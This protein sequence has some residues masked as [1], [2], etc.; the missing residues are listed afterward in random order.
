MLASFSFLIRGNNIS[1]VVRRCLKLLTRRDMKFPDNLAMSEQVTLD[2]RDANLSTQLSDNSLTAKPLVSGCISK[3][4]SGVKGNSSASAGKPY[5]IVTI[6]KELAGDAAEGQPEVLIGV[7]TRETTAAQLGSG[8]SW[9]YASSGRKWT[10]SKAEP[11][12]PMFA[13][14]DE[15]GCFLDLNSDTCTVSF[16]FNGTWLGSAYELPKPDHAQ[17]RLYPHIML[18]RLEATVNFTDAALSDLYT[19]SEEPSIYK[20][21]TVHDRPLPP[22]YEALLLHLVFIAIPFTGCSGGRQCV[23][24]QSCSICFFSWI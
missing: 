11:Y 7:S 23:C 10:A 2:Q 14:G 21:W 6:G 9:A 19:A 15:I 1:A 12:G 22:L 4:W 16:T 24:T 3:L 18:K 17:G 13:P 5:F 20:S 8:S